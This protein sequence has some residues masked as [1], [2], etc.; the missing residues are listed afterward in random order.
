MNNKPK[1]ENKFILAEF[2]KAFEEAQKAR[3]INRADLETD[4]LAKLNKEKPVKQLY[5]LGIIE[6]FIKI[7]D[8]LFEILDDMLQGDFRAKVFLDDHRLFFIGM[9]II[10]LVFI[11]HS[12]NTII[13]PVVTLPSNLPIDQEL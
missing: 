11:I 5:E 8:T 6:I 9:F 4:V 10:L 13:F 2:N 1:D 12:Y 3:E 7:K